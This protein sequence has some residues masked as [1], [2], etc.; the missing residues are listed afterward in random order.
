MFLYFSD[1]ATLVP[2]PLGRVVATKFLDKVGSIARDAAWEFY[3]VYAFQDLVVRF[4][5]IGSRERRGT[6]E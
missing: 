6:G 1:T 4:H 2:E 5:R 3:R